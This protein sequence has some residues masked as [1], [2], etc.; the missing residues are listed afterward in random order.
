IIGCGHVGSTLAYA[1]TQAGYASELVLVNRSMDRAEGEAEDLRHAVSLMSHKTKVS[2]GGLKETADSDAIAFSASIPMPRDM[3]SRN[4]LAEGNAEVL[5]QWIRP[6]AESSPNAVFVMITNPVEV[7]TQ[8][9]WKLSGLPH[10]Q[11]LGTGTIVDSARWR[12]MLSDYLGVHPDDIRAYILGEHGETQFPALSVSATGGKK[13]DRDPRIKELFREAAV[14]GLTVYKK[15]GY[16]NFAVAQAASLIIQT[17]LADERRSMPAS[18]LVSNYY[19]VD[20]VFLSVPVVVGRGGALR[21]LKPELDEQEQQMLQR[22]AE[23]VRRVYDSLNV[24]L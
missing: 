10:R 13:M 16:T 17:I 20:D 24:E 22:S 2:A 7:M 14:G 5:Q 15:K 9:A 6:L 19:G 18:T 23:T 12:S 8:L 1:V 21:T 11:F 4:I 3:K